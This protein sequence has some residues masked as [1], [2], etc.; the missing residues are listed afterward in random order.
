MAGCLA[1]AGAALFRHPSFWAEEDEA[2]AGPSLAEDARTVGS[3]HQV[4]NALVE[5]GPTPFVTNL[6]EA[7]VCCSIFDL[8]LAKQ[9]R[10][11]QRLRCTAE[12]GGHGGMGGK[13]SGAGLGQVGVPGGARWAQRWAQR[14]LSGVLSGVL[15]RHLPLPL[16]RPADFG[17][18]DCRAAY[19]ASVA[20]ENR[21]DRFAADA[22]PGAAAKRVL[23]RL[24]MARLEPVVLRGRGQGNSQFEALSFALFGT[25]VYHGLLRQWAVDYMAAQPEEYR[26]LLGADFPAYLAAMA[27]PGVAG[28]ELTLRA[29]GDHLGVAVNIVTA[30]AFMWMLRYA[31]RV[32]KSP[33]EVFVAFVPPGTWAPIRCAGRRRCR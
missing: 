33:R 27:R 31:P 2:A 6:D 5:S 28:D 1:G 25:P 18:R 19:E 21:S 30:D 26:P 7:S 16:P 22:E 13:R 11:L 29:V 17:W 12:P 4:F 3:E 24:L 23:G 32:T 10:P 8:A 9:G 14:V 20:S 15:S